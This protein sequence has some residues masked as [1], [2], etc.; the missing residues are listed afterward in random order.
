MKEEADPDVVLTHDTGCVTTLDKSQFAARAHDRN[1]GVP[2]M[3]EAQ[4]AALA[5]GAH[6]YKV[7]QLHWHSSNYKPLLVKMGID[8]EQAWAEFQE[9]LGKLERG[10]T[11]YLDWDDVG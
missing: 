3:S 9:D 5:M 2:V 6:P 1:V 10:E 11:K 7:C 8:P 4:F